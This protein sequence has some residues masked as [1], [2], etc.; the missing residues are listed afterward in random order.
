MESGMVLFAAQHN[1]G[2]DKQAM[3]NEAIKYIES[4]GYTQ[5]TVRMVDSERMILV[6]LR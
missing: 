6:I 1:D 5:E 4:N 3:I 2:D